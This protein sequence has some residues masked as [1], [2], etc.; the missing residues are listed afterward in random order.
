M[1]SSLG[2]TRSLSPLLRSIAEIPLR[3]A[4]PVTTRLPSNMKTACRTNLFGN[5]LRE[6][7]NRGEA[8]E[9]L[10]IRGGNQGPGV[11]DQGPRISGQRG[12][13]RG[14]LVAA[15]STECV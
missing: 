10:G 5:F 15:S 4:S 12:R 13:L 11:R 8:C 7:E 14:Q 1:A 6:N 2:S 9:G 3:M